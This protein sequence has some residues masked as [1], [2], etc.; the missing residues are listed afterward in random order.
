LQ[1]GGAHGAF[2]WGV[3]DALLEQPGWRLGGLSGASAGALNAVVLAH[4]LW[5][6]GARVEDRG[7]MTEVARQSA[8]AALERFWLAIAAGSPFE[9]HA[10]WLVQGAPQ[11]PELTPLARWMMAWATQWPPDSTAAWAVNPLREL[12]AAQL[13]LEGLRQSCPVPVFVS[14]T[15]VRNG[16]ARVFREHEIS[17]DVLL[18]STCLPRIHPSVV[19]EGETYWDGGY[20][21][22]P[23]LLP[24]LRG[25]AAPATGDT[26]QLL[27]VSLEASA[28]GDSGSSTDAIQ[29]RQAELGFGASI[30]QE[31]AWLQALQRDVPAHAPPWLPWARARRQP[32]WL[33]VQAHRIGIEGVGGATGESKLIATTAHVL[34]LR[35]AGRAAATGWLSAQV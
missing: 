22:N 32:R 23:P 24:L 26:R 20:S 7:A 19:I 33:D 2:T 27:L 3:L 18:A 13:D 35:D 25:V 6:G 14:A 29:R 9:Q 12:L 31:W 11:T 5:Q 10:P 1:G 21:A 30:A 16:Q 17:L 28:S 34:A 4:G 15:R 8:R